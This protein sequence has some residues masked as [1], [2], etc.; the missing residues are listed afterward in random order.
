VRNAWSS[1]PF[2]SVAPFD[3]HTGMTIHLPD[4]RHL[5]WAELPA[6]FPEVTAKLTKF[7]GLKPQD[8]EFVRSMD[9]KWRP[10]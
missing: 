3:A 5:V 7:V 9:K 1:P 2:T 6:A 8:D 4:D 10:S